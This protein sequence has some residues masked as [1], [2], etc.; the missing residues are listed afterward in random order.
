MLDEITRIDISPEGIIAVSVTYHD[1]N[2]AANIANSFVEELNRFNTETAMTAGKK[3]RIFI[4]KRLEENKDSL[5][6]AETALRAF[7]EK[8]RTIALEVEVESVI[9]TIAALKS[10]IILLEV[11]KGAIGSASLSNPY[12]GNINKRLRELKKQLAKIEIGSETDKKNG[13][14]VGF[15]IPL[16]E[17]PE[18]TLEY[19]RLYRDV[20]VQEA[21]FELLAQQYEQAKIME[22]KDTPTVQILDSAAPPE[23]K[24]YPQRT[25]I[26]LLVLL[27]SLF[28]SIGLVILRERFQKAKANKNAEILRWL[29]IFNQLMMEVKSLVNFKR[30]SGK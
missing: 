18:L 2:L 19:A 24:S 13:F 11:Q 20:K 15:S 22:A 10:E 9:E 27:A 26:T 23:E 7:Q 5:T 16:A 25:K 30:K 21:V 14:G 29:A 17:L 6:K 8:H 3:Y 4:E 28:V 12:T 1:K